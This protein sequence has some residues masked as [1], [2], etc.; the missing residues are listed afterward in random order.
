M[1]GKNLPI[2]SYPSYRLQGEITVPGDKSISHRAV[3]L[4]SIAKGTT[5]LSG[6]LE[7]EDCLSTVKAFTSMGVKIE[8]QSDNLL[9]HGV[10]LHSL[11][12]MIQS[13]D[14]GNSGTGM[15]LL[16]G[17]LAPQAFD[18]KLIG[19]LS[20]SKRPMDRII[21]PLS[22]MGAKIE[23]NL[24]TAPLV[25]RG[26]HQL[27]GIH[28]EMRT[29]SAQVKSG[30]LLAGLYAQG[31]TSI[32]E[33]SPSR[34]H[35]ELMLQAFSYPIERS[36]NTINIEGQSGE[37]QGIALNIPGDISSAAFF[38][39]AASLIPGA[40]LLIQSVGINPTRTG[41]IDILTRMGACIQIR[42][43]RYF[44]HEAVADLWIEYAPLN[45]IEI[46]VELIP[47]AIDE[48]PILFIAAAQAKG[49]TLLRGAAELRVKES[50]RIEAMA[51]GLRQLG[52]E[53]ETFNDGL[54]IE[55]D[56]LQSGKIDSH[57][58]HRVAMAFAIAGLVATGP[59]FIDDGSSITTSFPTFL[60]L[61]Q[62]LGLNIEGKIQ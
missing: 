53:V 21:Q 14:C 54:C 6:F 50:N 58:D 62:R 44:G 20:L 11:T 30:L 56:Q 42:N 17:L 19:D 26:G 45:G 36:G 46:P 1:I 33:P 40:K 48:F 35:T 3:I 24:G 38:M 39:V 27:R 9:I 10:G 51:V 4:G 15:R 31:C 22:L 16:T 13:I 43:R 32:V 47:S 25:I 29:A 18:S 34:D 12:P 28:Y 61:A 5:E 60:L 59:V 57:G 23:S 8:K 49:K 55:G 52:I 41:V 37:A 2:T 7:G